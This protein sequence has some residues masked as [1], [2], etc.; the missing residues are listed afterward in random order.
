MPF[1]FL[2]LTLLFISLK[3]H[4]IKFSH[5]VLNFIEA[6]L[7]KSLRNI[8]GFPDL[9]Y[10]TCPTFNRRPILDWVTAW[11]IV[12]ITFFQKYFPYWNKQRLQWL[13]SAFLPSLHTSQSPGS[14]KETFLSARCLF[15][16]AFEFLKGEYCFILFQ[17]CSAFPDSHLTFS[18]SLFLMTIF[19]L[20]HCFSFLSS[21]PAFAALVSP[22]GSVLLIALLPSATTRVFPL[23]HLPHP[24][25]SSPFHS[26]LSCL[27]SP[28]VFKGKPSQGQLSPSCLLL[29]E[30]FMNS[31][32][33]WRLCNFPVRRSTRWGWH[34][35]NPNQKIILEAESHS[36]HLGFILFNF[37][38]YF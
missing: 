38:T 15:P 24:C 35:T 18:S 20:P 32:F 25:F 29:I 8:W 28:K 4:T 26:L 36:S 10:S 6:F 21:S 30:Q 11:N 17:I 3:L 31:H 22:S 1:L 9:S 14:G 13:L 16:L 19:F 12:F 27:I 23:S 37:T 5:T 33:W 34:Q 2:I 7:T